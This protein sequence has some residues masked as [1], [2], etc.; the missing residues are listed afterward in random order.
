MTQRTLMRSLLSTFLFFLSPALHLTAH[1][2]ESLHESSFSHVEWDTVLKRYVKQ[3]GPVSYVMYKQIKE[4]PTGL[5]SYV[6]S[7]ETVTKEEFSKFSDPEKLAFLTNAYNA[8]TVKLIVDH[9]PVESI[10]DLGGL[11]SSPW[12]Q[13]FFTLFGEKHHL[14]DIE[15][16]MIRKT[17]REPRIHFALVC[18]SRGCP[19]LRSEAYVASRLDAQLDDAARTFLNDTQ[20]N[21]FRANESKVYL[22]MIFKWYKGD[23]VKSAGSVQTFVA[24][25]MGLSPQDRNK[26]LNGSVEVVTPDNYDWSLNDDPRTNEDASSPELKR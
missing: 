18:A 10:K 9:Y 15:H 12:K 5:L 11:F 23:F 22:S 24:R 1:S 20:R 3:D 13:K 6:K 26:F 16:E 8:L 25:Y 14:D 7:I 21:Y 2:A 17:F 4:K 19:S